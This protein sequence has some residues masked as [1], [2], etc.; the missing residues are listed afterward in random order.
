MSAKFKPVKLTKG[1]RTREA[2]TADEETS[3]RFNG[4]KTAAAEP[5]PKPSAPKSDSK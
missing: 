1:S 4:W 3:L 5:S 2:R